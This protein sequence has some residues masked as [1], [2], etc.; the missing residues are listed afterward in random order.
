MDSPQKK[1][2]NLPAELAF[3]AQFLVKPK[4]RYRTAHWLKA[5]FDDPVW[6]IG[7]ESQ[8]QID[9]RVRLGS[10]GPLLTA[11]PHQHLLETLKSWLIVQSHIDVTGGYAN[12]KDTEYR[13]IRRTLHCI[14]YLLLNADRLC[15]A[16]Q[17]M[18]A[19]SS[20]D[21]NAML[22][23][24]ASN[25]SISISIYAWPAHLSA[26]LRKCGQRI[27]NK[28]YKDALERHPFLGDSIVGI[29]DRLTDMNEIEIIQARIWLWQ[30]DF[31]DERVQSA[32]GFSRVPKPLASELFPNTVVG[33]TIP[34]PRA[35]EL[36]LLP[37]HYVQTEYPRVPVTTASDERMTKSV[38]TAYVPILTSLQLLAAEGLPTSFPRQTELATL[39]A[40]LDL[41]QAGR[42]RTP[43]ASVVFAA[44]RKATEFA[45]EFG[46]P[47]LES[48]TSLAIAAHSAKLSI[49][50]YV[51][52]H[53]ISP[54]LSPEVRKLGVTTWTIEAPYA[55]MPRVNRKC[56][57]PTAKEYYQALRNNTGLWECICVLFGAIQLVV[58]ALMARRQ[59]EL[60]DLVAGDCLDSS[61]TL[62]KFANRKSGV[63]GLREIEARP[64]PSL[65]VELLGILEQM[66]VRLIRAGLLDAH[67]AIFSC[68]LSRGSD[69]L[70]ASADDY[71]MWLDMFCDWAETDID[72]AGRRHYVR[73]HQLRRFFCMLFF[74]GNSF[75]GL[76][77]LRYFLG[78]TDPAHLYNYITES[79][80]GA[81]LRGA[82]ADWAMYGLQHGSAETAALEREL[83][84]HFGITSFEILQSDVLQ[85]YI[86]DLMEE[87][88]LKIEPE[89]LDGGNKYRIAV[90]LIPKG[91]EV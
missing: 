64:I 21:F 89:F 85:D 30:N 47:L 9:W 31:Y 56:A 16:E 78:Q 87:G 83:F 63:L 79:T 4:L 50:S 24:I 54:Y 34:H 61:K 71:A 76:E 80:P 1:A 51:R 38:L 90:R 39:T 22:S 26:W 66:Q 25:R 74:W 7:S 72:S 84:D 53:D 48:Y 3:I 33:K 44:F 23:M 37:G 41:K 43:P 2:Q 49:P 12:N 52:I 60:T 77:T 18:A 10:N 86:E 88:R 81:V 67:Q 62:L 91:V 73:Q 11:P 5:N 57:V 75:G 58:G 29:D 59:G 42:Y 82:A 28:D 19:L 14:D 27:T 65:G 15:L 45:L 35:L 46:A 8:F 17:G 40:S 32:S 36:C 6:I 13:R 70:L 68:P 69:R 20:N 55:A